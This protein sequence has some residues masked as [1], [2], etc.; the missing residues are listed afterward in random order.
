MQDFPAAHFAFK[1]ISER[2]IKEN[3]DDTSLSWRLRV[4]QNPIYGQC[5]PN[6]DLCLPLHDLS[7]PIRQRIW[8]G[9]ADPIR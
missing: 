9:N 6:C 4:P 8:Y 2:Q 3:A 5:A 1:L 7:D